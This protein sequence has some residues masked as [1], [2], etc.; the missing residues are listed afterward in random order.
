[1][2]MYEAIKRFNTQFGYTLEI[3]NASKLK[4]SKKLVV[5]GMGGSHLAADLLTMLGL[6][7]DVVIHKDYGLPELPDINERLV[8]ASSYS[9]NTEEPIS[10]FEEALKK[11]F[12]VAA[13][14]VGGK[15]IELAQK[16]KVPYVQLPD[17][18][19]QPRSALGVSLLAFFTLMREERML[20]FAQKLEHGLRPEAIEMEGKTLAK[21]LQNK[22]PVIY[23]SSKNWP[24]A[25][26]WKIKFNETGK[27]PAFYNVV[28][29]LNHNEM[30]GFDR[31]PRTRA[32]SKNFHFLLLSDATDD[33]RVQKRMEV[34]ASLYEDRRLPVTVLP[35]QGEDL[36]H[37]IFHSLLLADW[38]AYHTALLYEVDPEEVPMV[39]EFKRL[40]RK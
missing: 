28:P 24:I 5:V 27:I 35:L 4:K 14:S 29:E 17:L 31:K 38:A 20:S 11:G 36:L 8:I 3:Q 9:G 12:N 16:A 19:V 33:L 10:A 39:E 7:L 22:V 26:N 37:R 30:T 13:I 32:L 23:S 6:S 15:L 40:I 25:Y 34:L 18:H 21:T 1:M 2:N